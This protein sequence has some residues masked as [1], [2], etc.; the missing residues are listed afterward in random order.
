[1]TGRSLRRK[2]EDLFKVEFVVSV[3]TLFVA[4]KC[5]LQTIEEKRIEMKF[6]GKENG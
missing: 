3:L 6:K 4:L 1:M 2:E 5:L